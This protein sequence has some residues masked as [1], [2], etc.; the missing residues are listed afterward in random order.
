MQILYSEYL[1]E[2]LIFYRHLKNDN[3]MLEDES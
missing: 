3:A 1:A 2:P